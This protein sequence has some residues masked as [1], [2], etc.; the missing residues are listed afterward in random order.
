MTVNSEN[1]SRMKMD[2]VRRSQEMHRRSAVIR[3]RTE[4]GQ[5][6]DHKLKDSLI[7]EIFGS[8]KLDG[9]KLL[10]AALMY[11]LYREKADKKLI[12]ALGYIFL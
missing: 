9:D 5:G 7:T 10:I 11:L 3:D 1:M 4:V 12:I 6:E 2:A 8:N